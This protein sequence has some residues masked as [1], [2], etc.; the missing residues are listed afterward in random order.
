MSS[1]LSN[2]SNSHPPYVDD[3]CTQ[4]FATDNACISA[5]TRPN[6]RSHPFTDHGTSATTDSI[7]VL[8]HY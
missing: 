1:L 5:A 6:G 7:S 4:P 8:Y 3:S 2:T